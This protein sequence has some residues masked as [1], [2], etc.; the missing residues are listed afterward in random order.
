MGMDTTTTLI[1]L[2][3]AAFTRSY[4][5]QCRLTHADRMES[6]MPAALD[7]ADAVGIVDRPFTGAEMRVMLDAAKEVDSWR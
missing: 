7:A 5:G 1:E 6:F 2:L 3:E 4:I